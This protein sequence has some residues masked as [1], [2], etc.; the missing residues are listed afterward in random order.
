MLSPN[1]TCISSPFETKS[2][3]SAKFFS[4]TLL[5]ASNFG[6]EPTVGP[7]SSFIPAALNDLSTATE[8]EDVAASVWSFGDGTRRPNTP[9][10]VQLSWGLLDGL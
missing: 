9:D 10:R 5:F 7:L 3:A 2:S 4:R 1:I 6:T 8:L